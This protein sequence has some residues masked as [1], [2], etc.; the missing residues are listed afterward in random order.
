VY[1]ARE[2]TVCPEQSE[3]P[4][5]LSFSPWEKGRLHNGSNSVPS[6]RGRGTG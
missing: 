6:P 5:I 4:L 3:S 2:F 1:A